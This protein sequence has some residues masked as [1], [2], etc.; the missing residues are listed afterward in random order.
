MVCSKAARCGRGMHPVGRVLSRLLVVLM[1]MGY[2]E[3]NYCC[4]TRKPNMDAEVK[5]LALATPDLRVVTADKVKVECKQSK[6]ELI[7]PSTIYHYEYIQGALDHRRVYSI[8]H[9]P[10]NRP[11]SH[12]DANSR[13]AQVVYSAVAT[14]PA[15]AFPASSLSPRLGFG[16]TKLAKRQFHPGRKHRVGSR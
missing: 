9:I 13:L 4:F 12:P 8:P 15:S 6:H 5:L 16:A 10:S 3:M 1:M 2:V 14:E 11:R 7:N